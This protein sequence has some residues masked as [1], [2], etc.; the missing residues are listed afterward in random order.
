[1][2]DELYILCANLKN[3][4]RDLNQKND[5]SPTE[6]DRVYKA[7]DIIKDIKTIE[8]MEEAGYSNARGG[9]SRASYEGSYERGRSNMYPGYFYDEPGMSG[10]RGGNSRDYSEEGSY[11]RGRDAMGRYTSREGGYS[12]HEEEKE[13]MMRQIDDMRHRVQQM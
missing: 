7:I 11:R 4:I 5:I 13:Q 8:A 12:G 1:M 10:A 9:N 6:L 2:T 3:E